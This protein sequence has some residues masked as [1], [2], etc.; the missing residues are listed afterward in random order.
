MH[1]DRTLTLRGQRFHYT[2]WG[3]STAP[4]IVV[5]HGITGHARTWDDE[6]RLLAARLRVLVLDQRGHGDSDPAPDGD[7]G[8]AALLGDLE[9][10]AEALGL[11]RF[12]LLALSL[13]GRVAMNF[14][15]RHPGRVTRLVVVDIGPEIAPAGRG[16]V[17]M[18]MASAPEHF[19]S[20]DEVVAHMRANNPRYT[21]AMLRHR[22]EHAVRPAPGGGLTWKYD[23][24]LREAIRQGR[25]RVPAD[26]WPQWRAIACP[27]L[28]VRGAESDILTEETAKRMI[29]ELPA[30]RL[31]VVAGAGHTVPGDQPAAFQSLL[32]EF[33]MP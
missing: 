26:L 23:R 6:A 12:A 28:L 33:L 4:P 17:G 31:V 15:G 18:L 1:T 24:A 10:F 19:A 32:R 2:E 21:E 8:D 20:V 3:A 22:A 11:E 16:R 13:G 30:A 27:T 25:L 9:A 14:A 5:L 7:Y 29:D